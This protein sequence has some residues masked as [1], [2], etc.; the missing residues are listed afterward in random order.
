M[1][2]IRG[3]ITLTRN[4]SWTGVQPEQQ[5]QSQDR[6]TDHGCPV[7]TM[8]C[9]D[10]RGRGGL[11]AKTAPNAFIYNFINR[12]IYYLNIIIIILFVSSSGGDHSGSRVKMS[13]SNDSVRF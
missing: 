9:R 1:V 4:S 6:R 12:R 8:I 11:S 13:H 5:R 10:L 2:K 7:M 3:E